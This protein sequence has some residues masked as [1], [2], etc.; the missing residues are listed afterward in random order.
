MSSPSTL[1]L[2]TPEGEPLRQA[3]AKPG[4]VND[5]ALLVFVHDRDIESRMFD[6][7][8]EPLAWKKGPQIEVFVEPGKKKAK[9]VAHVSVLTPGALALSQR[10]EDALEPFLSRFGQLLEMDCDGKSRWFYNVTN[11]LACIDD[12]RSAKKPNGSISKEEFFEDI[13]C[14]SRQAAHSRVAPNP[15]NDRL[16]ERL[17]VL[18]VNAYAA[19]GMGSVRGLEVKVEHT[20]ALAVMPSSPALLVD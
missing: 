18:V 13:K 5:Y 14:L 10:S 6:A 12:V 2:S 11:V 16:S 3:T 19:V 20:L 4:D 8:G 15:A 1:G 17:V 9:P 7:E